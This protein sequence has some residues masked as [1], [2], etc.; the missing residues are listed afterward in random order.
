MSSLLQELLSI[1]EERDIPLGS[2]DIAWALERP[3]TKKALSSWMA[4]HLTSKT[5]LTKPELQ[6]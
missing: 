6:L 4:E 1:L 3:A 2:D 5:L